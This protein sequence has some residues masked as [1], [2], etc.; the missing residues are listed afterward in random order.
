MRQWMAILVALTAFL[1]ESPVQAWRKGSA[2]GYVATSGNGALCATVAF[3]DPPPTSGWWCFNNTFGIGNLV[4]GTDFTQ[5][6]SMQANVFPLNT[7]ISWRYPT[8]PNG[9]TGCG[10]FAYGYPEIVYGRAETGGNPYKVVGPWFN[11]VVSF[12]GNTNG[13][14]LTVTS[15]ASNLLAVGQLVYSPYQGFQA[16]NDGT[17]ILS[18][19]SGTPGGVGAYQLSKTQDASLSGRTMTAMT[20]K[21]MGQ[22]AAFTI[23][24]DLTISGNTLAFDTLFDLYVNQNFAG[25]TVQAEISYFPQIN[26]IPSGL[27]NKT[28]TTF[29]GLG[30]TLVGIQGAQIHVI[31]TTGSCTVPRN[32]SA[33]KFDFKQVFNYLVSVNLGGVSQ[34]NYPMGVQAG[35]EP[36]VP[37]AYNSGAP[38]GT[39]IFNK[40]QVTWQ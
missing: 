25:T 37:A 18:Q 35:V 2:V 29:T 8:P 27:T 14:T 36:Q 3:G 19:L 6:V 16:T 39:L 30:E 33:A 26:F 9:C 21:N 34:S 20:G 28:C 15:I 12:V 1:F 4:N 11:P 5:S 40:M 32:L 38:V 23:D 13:T 31:P 24:Y 22:I 17:T 10:G 7:V